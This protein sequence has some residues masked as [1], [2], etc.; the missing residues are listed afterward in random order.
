MMANL[1]HDPGANW[2]AALLAAMHLERRDDIQVPGTV[3]AIAD[4]G[5]GR[6]EEPVGRFDALR[7]R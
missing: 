4:F 6:G 7:D 5:A 1:M 2:C 3:A